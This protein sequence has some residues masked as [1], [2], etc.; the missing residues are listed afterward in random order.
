MPNPR[1]ACKRNTLLSADRVAD[2]NDLFMA[3]QLRRDRLDPIDAIWQ[4]YK[5]DPDTAFD[6]RV[7]LTTLPGDWE[8]M[9]ASFSRRGLNHTWIEHPPWCEYWFCCGASHRLFKLRADV[10]FELY[11]VSPPN[12]PDAALVTYDAP[13]RKF[14]V[15]WARLPFHKWQ[16]I[17]IFYRGLLN[18][19]DHV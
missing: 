15:S 5:V 2:A 7:C 14:F 16:N 6:D 12:L 1:Q 8:V 4:R 13:Y 17:H 19:V 9:L 10:V 11:I 3:A 18:D